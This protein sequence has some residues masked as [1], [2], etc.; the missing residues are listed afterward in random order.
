MLKI[1]LFHLTQA[2][3]DRVD[4][5]TASNYANNV[6]TKAAWHDNMLTEKEI[7]QNPGAVVLATAF[8]K[9]H[10]L[11]RGLDAAQVRV[12]SIARDVPSHL[13]AVNIDEQ[14]TV[15]YPSFA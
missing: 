13:H 10:A 7:A 2:N 9:A 14:K 12:T 15:L 8:A 6:A 3:A 4:F 11:H 5:T 1:C